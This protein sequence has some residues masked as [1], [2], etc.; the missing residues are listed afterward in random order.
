MKKK[1]V[2]ILI[3]IITITTITYAA[4]SLLI[5]KKNEKES[6]SKNDNEIVMVN[7]E[8]EII[9]NKKKEIFEG[10]YFNQEISLI[11]I[12]GFINKN[13]KNYENFEINYGDGNIEKVD[14][15]GDQISAKHIYRK[16]GEYTI[17]F[18][19]GNVKE[20]KKIKINE[21]P[22]KFKDKNLEKG[23]EKKFKKL[24]INNNKAILADGL[25]YPSQAKIVKEI[26][27]YSGSL[28]NKEIESIKGLKHFTNLK[29]LSLVDNKIN[30][31]DELKYLK[32]LEKL[33]LMN[34]EINNIKPIKNLKNLKIID[35]SD[36]RI[37][38]LASVRELNS[39]RELTIKNN[40]NE[41]LNKIDFSGSKLENIEKIY[42][43]NTNIKEINLGN[44]GVKNL[45]LVNS[46]IN[47][48]SFLTNLKELES[49]AL[50]NLDINT[51]EPLLELN[52]L[53]SVTI[54]IPHLDRFN[55][56]TKHYKVIEK[57]K[58]KG[59]IIY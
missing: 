53:K 50:K 56:E 21:V 28:N 42:L 7:K 12:K 11:N 58:E 20:S 26:K 41:K 27:K 45:K 5:N 38:D 46:P 48:I 54:E 8:K 17:I 47:D 10:E 16:K 39:L 40:Q 51:L 9:I 33:Y 25:I 31:I 34:N 52:N 14:L 18:K 23:L 44:L 1:I 59:V 29:N 37:S 57:L 35:L 15:F 3:L 30:N 49:L 36:N 32:K 6:K 19:A 55:R 13:I 22:I 2:I 43:D 24:R 4:K